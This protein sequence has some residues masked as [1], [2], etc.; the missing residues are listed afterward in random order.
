MIFF[1]ESPADVLR[2]HFGAVGRRLRWTDPTIQAWV[3][4]VAVGVSN[5]GVDAIDKQIEAEANQ[6]HQA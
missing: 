3:S 2:A 5:I 4:E 1:F 6:K